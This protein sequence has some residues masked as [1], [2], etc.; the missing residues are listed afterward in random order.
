MVCVDHTCKKVSVAGE[1]AALKKKML[2]CSR[3]C[4][5][6]KQGEQKYSSTH[7]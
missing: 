5:E 2:R 6:D 1:T 4:L 3:A 7:S